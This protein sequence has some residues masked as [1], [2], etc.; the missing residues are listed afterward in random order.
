[1]LRLN[2][3][4]GGTASSVDAGAAAA[5]VA[6][7]GDD[8]VG[9]QTMK[10][11]AQISHDRSDPPINDAATSTSLVISERSS[12]SDATRRMQELERGAE[13]LDLLGHWA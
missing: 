9:R 2:S 1:M 12:G 8:E 7:F 11:F 13:G 6:A 3:T 10:A 4:A 5:G